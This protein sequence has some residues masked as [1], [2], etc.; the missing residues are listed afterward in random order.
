MTQPVPATLM[1]S[2]PE[3]FGFT[4][5]LGDQAIQP[6]SW[7]SDPAFWFLVL[8]LQDLSVVANEIS[9]SASTVPASVAPYAGKVGYFLIFVTQEAR[10]GMVPT[11]E[12]AQF[13]FQVGADRELRRLEQLIEQAGTGWIIRFAYT[14]GAT[15]DDG[16]LP[17]MEAMSINDRTYLTLEFRP[18]EDAQGEPLGY[19]ATQ[20]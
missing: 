14:L 3:Q 13:L 15:T 8:K 11:G 2:M 16:D 9:T 20:L 17:G 1:S 12:L 4:V 19:A 6:P 7:P 18:I 5:H 10:A